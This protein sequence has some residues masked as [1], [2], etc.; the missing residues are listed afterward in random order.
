MGFFDDLGNKIS[1]AIDT[2]EAAVSNE[3][4]YVSDQ[5]SNAVDTAGKVD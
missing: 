1:D 5:V 4:E 2:A 3:V